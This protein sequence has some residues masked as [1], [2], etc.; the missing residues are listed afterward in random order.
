MAAAHAAGVVHR[1]LKPSNV[2]LTKQGVVKIVDF[3]IAKVDSGV[4]RLTETGM[5]IGTIPYM[6]PEQ[7]MGE[8]IDHRS[9]IWSLGVVLFEMLT[10]HLPFR[11]E[12]ALKVIHGILNSPVPEMPAVAPALQAVVRE[13]LAKQPMDRYQ[14]ASALVEALEA[15]LHR[16]DG[17]C[18]S[19]VFCGTALP[20]GMARCSC[21]GPRSLRWSVSLD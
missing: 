11:G 3:G 16:P 8:A 21:R 6:S 19:S 9:D 14:N 2:I 5:L 17:G 1:D 18:Q 12:N 10:G 13:S 20:E 15:V 7:A 4:V